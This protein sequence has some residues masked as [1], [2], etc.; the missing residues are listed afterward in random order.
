MKEAA[1]PIFDHKSRHDEEGRTTVLHWGTAMRT[2][3]IALASIALLT[4]PAYSQGRGN[5]GGKDPYADAQAAEQKKKAAEAE[6]AY[7]AAVGSI[8]DKP[9]YDPWRST[10]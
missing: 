3:V 8:P 5:H 4:A 6:K 2:V 10:R 1:R 9:R 7:N